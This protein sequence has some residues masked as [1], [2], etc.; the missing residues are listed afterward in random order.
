MQIYCIFLYLHTIKFQWQSKGQS[1]IFLKYFHHEW[2]KLHL[3]YL[4]N[5]FS[6]VMV[7]WFLLLV[8]HIITSCSVLEVNAPVLWAVDISGYFLLR[9]KEL[10]ISEDFSLCSVSIY[11]SEG[12]I[13]LFVVMRCPLFPFCS[14]A[15]HAP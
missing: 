8:F 5:T 2:I 15:V 14:S 4:Y 1:F 9:R 10:H 13:K 12:K 3:L 11:C 6:A 7:L